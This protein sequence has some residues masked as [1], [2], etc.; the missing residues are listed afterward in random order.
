MD[1]EIL[2][3]PDDADLKR[4]NTANLSVDYSSHNS[5]KYNM[6]SIAEEDL[7]HSEYSRK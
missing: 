7:E 5:N 2:E 1:S 6:N 3:I 4:S